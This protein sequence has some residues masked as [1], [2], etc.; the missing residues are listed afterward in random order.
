MSSTST[1]QDDTETMEHQYQN[2]GYTPLDEMNIDMN[3]IAYATLG[4]NETDD[5]DSECTNSCG[6]DGDNDPELADRA[7]LVL[8]TEYLACVNQKPIVMHE[9]DMNANA[10]DKK[11]NDST[12]PDNSNNG[13]EKDTVIP[14]VLMT[15]EVSD[16]VDSNSSNDYDDPNLQN[17][18]HMDNS[19]PE[20]VIKEAASSSSI[21]M[22]IA[23]VQSAMQN[24]RLK[25]PIL[26]AKLDAKLQQRSQANSNVDRSST[27]PASIIELFS[28]D[29]LSAAISIDQT[30]TLSRSATL[31]AAIDRIFPTRASLSLTAVTKKSTA[32]NTLPKHLRIHVIGCDHVECSSKQTMQELFVPFCEWMYSYKNSN[33]SSVE[34]ID[35]ELIGPG[36]PHKISKVY[37]LDQPIVIALKPADTATS[38]RTV[39]LRTR[40]S[41]TTDTYE[42]YQTRNGSIPNLIIA[43]NAGVWGYSSW[44]PTLSH[45]ASLQQNVPFVITA[46]TKLEAE[47]DEDVIANHLQCLEL[48]GTLLWE[49][50]VNFYRCRKERETKSAVAGRVYNENGAWQCWNLGGS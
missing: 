7:L 6:G 45:I 36:V 41:C 38:S 17:S 43:F 46:Y 2:Q 20:D 26:S 16:D 14:A 25:N 8:D 32:I 31:M 22:N 50:E 24:M 9:A 19:S 33:G 27:L 34:L 35:L 12:M 3:D 1:H 40:I 21:D 44:L 29:D 49:P 37:S 48:G 11:E 47:E 10:G 4:D 15:S 39:A 13:Q 30:V 5:T 42:D 28:D 18:N 23:A